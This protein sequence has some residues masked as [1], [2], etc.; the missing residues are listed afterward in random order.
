[1]KR[2]RHVILA[3]ALAGIALWQAGPAAAAA[4]T[5]QARCDF[6][7]P[8]TK[9]VAKGTKVI[10]RSVCDDHTVTSYGGNW[11][12][13]TVLDQGQS[14]SKTFAAKGTFR[15]RCRFHS[16]LE[17]STCSGMCGKVVVG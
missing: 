14:T 4:A 10:W 15:Y 11:A 7:S 3:G 16:D 5:V 8:A 2:T 6:F 17:G 13:N 12:K 1:M 9:S